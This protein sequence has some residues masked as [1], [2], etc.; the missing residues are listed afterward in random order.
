MLH[1]SIKN[2]IKAAMLAKNEVRLSVLRD[3]SSK[4]TNELVSKGRMPQDKLTDEE[5]LAVIK[6]AVKQRKDSIQQF[7]DGGRPEL[8]ESEKVE[9]AELET[10]LPAQM[11]KEQIKEIAQAKIAEMGAD[12]TKA[13][14][15]I[16]AVMKECKGQADGN[17]VKAVVD[18][19]LA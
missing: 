3:L 9:L 19:L 13:G 4:F 17:D 7:T 18:E 10:F 15:V 11:G 8:A 1:D 6:R 16:G 14:M 12:K 2:G 5:A